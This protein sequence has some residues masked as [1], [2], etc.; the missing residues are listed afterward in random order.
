M[1]HVEVG[2]QEIPPVGP[3]AWEDSY[4]VVEVLLRDGARVAERVDVPKGSHQNPLTT[5]ELGEKFQV[6]AAQHP[7]GT[8]DGARALRLVRALR[9]DEDAGSLLRRILSP[10]EF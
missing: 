3:P 5:A 7:S 1:K 10:A 2:E 4:A 8:I 9:H 6:C